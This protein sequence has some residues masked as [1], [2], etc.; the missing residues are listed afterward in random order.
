[1]FGCR[2]TV[3]ALVPRRKTAHVFSVPDTIMLSQPFIKPLIN[4]RQKSG[5]VHLAPLVHI[6]GPLFSGSRTN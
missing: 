2:P 1:M 5:A 6:N 4:F 3:Q